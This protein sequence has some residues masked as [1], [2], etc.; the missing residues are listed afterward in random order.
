MFHQEATNAAV[1]AI[2]RSINFAGGSADD[3][4]TA[5]ECVMAMAAVQIAN[6]G[7]EAEL[8]R[9]LADGATQRIASF[10]IGATE[11]QGSA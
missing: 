7:K 4:A 11:T 10:R 6:P 1:Y 8:L 2:V 3:V 5:L 9:R